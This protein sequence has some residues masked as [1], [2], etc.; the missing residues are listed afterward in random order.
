MEDSNSMV[1]KTSKMELEG[2]PL[3]LFRI[4]AG[5]MQAIN[6][7]HLTSLGTL[8]NESQVPPKS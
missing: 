4:F 7:E 1:S 3:G 6:L 2:F 5:E 8:S